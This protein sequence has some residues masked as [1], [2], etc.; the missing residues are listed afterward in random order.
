[1]SVTF[2]ARPFAAQPRWT[3]A[4]VCRRVLV[5]IAVWL[6]TATGW[7]GWTSAAA[8]PPWQPLR[9]VDAETRTRWLVD[10]RVVDAASGKPIPVFTVTPGSLSTDERGRTELRLRENLAKDMRDG[11]LRWPRTSGFA[12]MR[13]RISAEGY[14]P[15]VTQRIRRGGP[16]IRMRIR[17]N[18]MAE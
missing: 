11:T 9:S 14:R 17:L 5:V 16:H 4:V 2:T 12:E 18:Q 13:F 3:T 1:M 7:N 15:V 8:A 10:G 6:A